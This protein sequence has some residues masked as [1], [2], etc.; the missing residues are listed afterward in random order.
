MKTYWPFIIASAASSFDVMINALKGQRHDFM[1][2]P[3]RNVVKMHLMIFIIA[4]AGAAGLHQ[5]V[6]YAALFLYFFPV[7]KI[8][9]NLRASIPG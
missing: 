6:L 9:K 8:I 5:Y 3:Y 4:F 1:L 7:R 2:E